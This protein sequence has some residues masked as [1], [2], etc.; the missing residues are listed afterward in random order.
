MHI[1]DIEETVKC[2]WFE[3]P[4]ESHLTQELVT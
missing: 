2:S 3:C 4:Y 1:L